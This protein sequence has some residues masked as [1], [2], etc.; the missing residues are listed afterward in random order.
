MPKR[1]RDQD[2]AAGLELSPI[3]EELVSKAVKVAKHQMY[4]E[5]NRLNYEFSRLLQ[6]SE[7][8]TTH[9][10]TID[11]EYLHREISCEFRMDTT[12]EDE[13]V[14]E[15]VTTVRTKVPAE[16]NAVMQ[17]LRAIHNK[18]RELEEHWS[19]HNISRAR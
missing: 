12:A 16:F 15:I 11:E 19:T 8:L 17:E 2:E 7:C 10:S 9:W 13:A 14:P 1:T 3:G 5:V 6:A 4:S 18:L